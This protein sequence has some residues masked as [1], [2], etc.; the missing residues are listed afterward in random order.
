MLCTSQARTSPV[1]SRGHASLRAQ[2]APRAP[3]P[4]PVRLTA[5]EQQRRMD[6]RLLRPD[7]GKGGGEMM[8]DDKEQ[9]AVPPGPEREGRGAQKAT[10]VHAGA[11]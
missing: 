4:E 6:A 5:A 8:A 11:S 1:L 10:R 7:F 9:F 2:A 3:S